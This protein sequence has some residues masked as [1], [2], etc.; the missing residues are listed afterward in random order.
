MP[1]RPASHQPSLRGLVLAGSPLAETAGYPPEAVRAATLAGRIS[2]AVAHT[3]REC[4]LERDEIAERMGAFLGER[5][6][7]AMLNAYASQARDDHNI[8][9][10]RLIALAYATSDARLLDLLAAELG[11]AVVSRDDLA[12]IEMLRLQDEERALR[13]RMDELRRGLRGGG[14]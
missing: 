2:R 12:R 10:V 3:L 11:L 4:A 6:S 1:R 14:A 13:R 5:V 9:A 8:S 7:T